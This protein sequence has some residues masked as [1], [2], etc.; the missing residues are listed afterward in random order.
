M[1]QWV[2]SNVA[3]DSVPHCNVMLFSAVPPSSPTIEAAIATSSTVIS[4]QWGASADDGGSLLTSYVIEYRLSDQTE[5]S[6]ITV[7]METLSATI[8]GLTPYGQ[9]EVRVRGENAVGRGEPSASLLA[10]THPDGG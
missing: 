7:S 10:R 2:W 4:V 8:S 3:G 9:Y 6:D 5:F 1:Y